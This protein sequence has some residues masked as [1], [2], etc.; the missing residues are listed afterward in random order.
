MGT[1]VIQPLETTLSL[2]N[3]FQIHILWVHTFFFTIFI[4]LGISHLKQ[5]MSSWN[6]DKPFFSFFT[7]V[8]CYNTLLGTEPDA[9]NADHV[10]A[11]G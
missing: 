2:A 1:C 7:H 11:L 8:L 10:V 6:K 3:C 9:E 5:T 4:V